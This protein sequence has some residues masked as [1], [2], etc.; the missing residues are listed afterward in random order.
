MRAGSGR[1]TEDELLA[2]VRKHAAELLRFARRHSLCDDD[3]H[4]AYQ[5]TLEILLRRM[6]TDPPERPLAWL[7]TVLKHECAAVR[8]QREQLVEHDEADLDGHA[9]RHQEDP[10]ERAIGF[11]RLRHTAEALQR[12]KPQELTALLLRAEG[13]SYREIGE[14]TSW[15]ATKVNR[16][17]TEG[18][19]ALLSRLGAI[20]S[21]AECMRWLPLLSRLADGEADAADLAQLRPHLRR[22]AGCRATLRALHDAPSAVAALVPPALALGALAA[23]P[24]A[25]LERHA[26]GLVHALLARTGLSARAQGAFDALHARVALGAARVEGAF[27]AL[28]ARVALGAARVQ[29]A[30]DALPGAKLAAVAA[31]GAALAGGGIAISQTA[32][33]PSRPVPARA[34]AAAAPAATGALPAAW[35]APAA[36]GAHGAGAAARRGARPSAFGEFAGP[37]EFAPS[38]RPRAE[39]AAR[40]APS[41][42]SGARLARAASAFAAPAPPAAAT[43]A[44]SP[45]TSRPRAPQA[46]PPAAAAE[47]AGP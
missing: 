37:R 21:G 44:P 28:H 27:D 29:S 30:L 45:T 43:S 9:A 32:L 25:A 16:C 40:A 4:D 19:R 23:P 14:R 36:L 31:S 6:R 13:F 15:S 1:T 26:E 18:R 33:A 24:G 39:F 22:C 35:L 3:A 41:A 5:R 17:V 2:L 7:R 10:A 11:E 38:V 34:V 12:L 46:A 42:P 47:F 8:A 20:E